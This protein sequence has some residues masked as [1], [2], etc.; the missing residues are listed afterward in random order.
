MQYSAKPPLQPVTGIVLTLTQGFPPRLA[1]L[2]VQTGIMQ[3]G[4][5]HGIID[6]EAGDTWTNCGN[7]AGDFM[8]GDEW[9]LRF[10]RPVTLGRVQVG[11]AHAARPDPNEQLS[12]PGCRDRNLLDHQ[13]VAKTMHHRRRS[14]SAP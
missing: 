6:L 10:H 11:V 4:N 12:R 3:P 5:A 14:S 7:H 9:G 13:W 1:I 8:T 2:A